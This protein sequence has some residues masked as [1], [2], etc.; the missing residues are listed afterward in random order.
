MLYSRGCEKKT[1]SGGHV[2][3]TVVTEKV[4]LATDFS[5]LSQMLPPTPL[6][7]VLCMSPFILAPS[8]LLNKVR[9]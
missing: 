4:T 6:P 5:V 3:M 2:F 7:T 9:N 1:G 8:L